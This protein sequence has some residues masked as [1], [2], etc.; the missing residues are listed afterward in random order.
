MPR[1]IPLAAAALALPAL[2]AAQED[3]LD[4]GRTGPVE[5]RD[6]SYLRV[7]EDVEVRTTDGQLVGEI[8]DV[9]LDEAGRPA[10][11]VVEIDGF[12]GILDRDVQVPMESLTWENSHFVSKMTEEQLENL[13]PWDE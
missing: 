11:Y 4:E 9:L 13:A 12:L 5:T 2:A 8:E 7:A 3:A 6:A 1:L 10:G